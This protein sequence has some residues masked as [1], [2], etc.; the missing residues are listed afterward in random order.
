MRNQEAGFVHAGDL[1]SLSLLNGDQI[2]A[3]NKVMVM[4]QEGT[5]PNAGQQATPPCP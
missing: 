5:Q 2:G 4:R 3:T 1:V